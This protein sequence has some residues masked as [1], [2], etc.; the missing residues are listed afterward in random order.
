MVT[1]IGIDP[2]KATHTAVAIDGSEMVLGEITVAADRT[3]PR[4]WW[5][6]LAGW[7]VMVACGRLRLPAVSVTCCP[8][9]WSQRVNRWLMCRRCWHHECGCSRRA[10]LRRTTP[11]T[12]A[13]WRSRRCVN[14]TWRWCTGR[15]GSLKKIEAILV[16][17]E[18]GK[19]TRLIGVGEL[20]LKSSHAV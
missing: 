2:H 17:V 18:R 11:T 6:G 1:T 19:G 9:S 3:R 13:Q 4:S 12:P 7:M 5:S 15:H 20:Y 14:P 8:S 10:V 16:H